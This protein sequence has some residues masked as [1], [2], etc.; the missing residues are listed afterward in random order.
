MEPELAEKLKEILSVASEGR[1][2][3][4]RACDTSEAAHKASERALARTGELEQGLVALRREIFGSKPPPA[5]PPADGGDAPP[6]PLVRRVADSHHELAAELETTQGEVDTFQG[7]V[8]REFSL[9]RAELA[10]QSRAMGLGP[11][12]VEASK[13][14]SKGI[15]RF[16]RWARTAEGR[17]FVI[18][19]AAVMTAIASWFRPVPPPPPP[20]VVRL[21]AAPSTSVHAPQA[22][23]S[24]AGGVR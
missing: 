7:N 22:G 12:V 10:A 19:A 21:E 24:Y 15:Q 18:A 8:L 14:A 5:E 3:A 4:R 11:A 6:V 20:A 9:V 23:T 13:E 16:T 17:M 2:F 1:S